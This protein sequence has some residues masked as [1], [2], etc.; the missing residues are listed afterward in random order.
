MIWRLFFNVLIK[1]IYKYTT[2]QSIESWR[3]SWRPQLA[4]YGDHTWGVATTSTPL[5][6]IGSS[7]CSKEARPTPVRPFFLYYLHSR[8]KKHIQKRS[9]ISRALGFPNFGKFTT[10]Y[11]ISHIVR[12]GTIG[13]KLVI[14]VTVG[15]KFVKFMVNHVVV[16]K[17]EFYLLGDSCLTI[18]QPFSSF[19]GGFLRSLRYCVKILGC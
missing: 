5:V 6:P 8:Y 19:L 15:S 16:A 17:F 2:D 7:G 14:I 13:T 9:N 3:L 11:H 1:H 12:S 4:R 10:L 18:L